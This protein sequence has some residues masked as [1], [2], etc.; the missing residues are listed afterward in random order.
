MPLALY[1]FGQFI[2]PADD[3]ANDGFRDL[4]AEI[5]RAA[6]DTGGLLARSG[7]DLDEASASAWGEEV[8]PR[9]YDNRGDGWVPATLSLWDSIEASF[10]FTY[11]GLHAQALRR[12][13]EWFREGNWPPL[14]MW[15]LPNDERGTTWSEGVKRYEHLHDF[16]A[17]P[18]AFTFKE[19]FNF[20]G[21]PMKIDKERAR[22][23]RAATALSVQRAS[24]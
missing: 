4:A 10:A 20:E 22:Q 17:S 8:F 2:E 6:D 13:R 11:S 14:V 12:R 24:A 23:L 3:E 1:T 18:F 7:F 16:G 9:F 15:W 5:F 19:P 21:K